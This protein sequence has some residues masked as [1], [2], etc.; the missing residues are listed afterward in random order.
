MA[1]P[2][3][4]KNAIWGLF[5][6][7]CFGLCFYL[8]GCVVDLPGRVATK[9]VFLYEH[10]EGMLGNERPVHVLEPGTKCHAFQGGMKV[11]F[12]FRIWCGGQVYGWT[13]DTAAFE[14]PLDMDT[15]FQ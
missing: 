1:H 13:D 9:P 15:V 14:P 3:T 10:F 12:N 2:V 4:G 5:V 7:A 11:V 8:G 6:L